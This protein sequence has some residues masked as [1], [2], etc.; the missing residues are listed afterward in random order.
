MKPFVITTLLTALQLNQHWQRHFPFLKLRI[1]TPEG[2]TIRGGVSNI[3]L[4]K[5]SRKEN[6]PKWLVI[7]PTITINAFEKLFQTTF[8]LKAKVLRKAGYTWND[9]DHCKNQ[10]LVQ[11]NNRSPERSLRQ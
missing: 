10:K 1:Y 9:T 8:G 5:I 7:Y 6:G 4:H 11:Q 2:R 3:P